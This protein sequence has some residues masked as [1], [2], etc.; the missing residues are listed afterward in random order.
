M[1]IF[2]KGFAENVR[3]PD[4]K[5]SLGRMLTS[6]ENIATFTEVPWEKGP[7]GVAIYDLISLDMI[8][9]PKRQVEVLKRTL[10]EDVNPNKID[11][12]V[13]LDFLGARLRMNMNSNAR[14]SRGEF[15]TMGQGM[16][17]AE[18]KSFRQKIGEGFGFVK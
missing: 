6:A 11:E 3:Q 18:E 15:V 10:G 12:G 9:D 1:S 4:T 8:E 2:E 5:E 16:L 17:W 7:F 14:K 13:Y